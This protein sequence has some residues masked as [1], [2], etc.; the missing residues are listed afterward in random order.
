VGFRSLN[1]DSR[2]LSKALQAGVRTSMIMVLLVSLNGFESSAAPR[3]PLVLKQLAETAYLL[4]T[5]QN[6]Q[7]L[8]GGDTA[9]L[10]NL[11]RT[12]G[13]SQV[14]LLQVETKWLAPKKRNIL[15]NSVDKSIN[16]LNQACTG[17]ES[18][19]VVLKRAWAIT[20]KVQKRLATLSQSFSSQSL[21]SGGSL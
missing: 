21:Q 4:R 19:A 16:E 7:N 15:R 6:P 18:P 14:L 1:Y 11:C 8:K 13:Q 12:I 9:V 20:G 2:S 5:S 3:R 17:S 10:M